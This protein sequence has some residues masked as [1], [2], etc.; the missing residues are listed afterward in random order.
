MIKI[1][2]GITFTPS[3]F[4]TLNKCTECGRASK[5]DYGGRCNM[6]I[7]AERKHCKV[8]DIILRTGSQRYYAYDIKEEYRGDTYEFKANKNAVCEFYYI[9]D[10]YY[11]PYSEDMC[12]GCVG[13][14]VLIQNRCWV[15]KD[16]FDNSVEHYKINGNTCLAC[17]DTDLP[18]EK[19]E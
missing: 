1:P 15:C 17:A 3:E 9:K 11:P 4:K 2:T 7:L 16:E 12:I 18:E 10:S 14:E 8:C 5:I 6:C 13:F 19:H